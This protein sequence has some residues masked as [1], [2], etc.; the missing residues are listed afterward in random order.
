M[1][2]VLW[3]ASLKL[4]LFI[5]LLLGAVAL[6]LLL[7][8]QVS[9]WVVAVPLSMLVIN[10]LAAIAVNP[11]F[12]VQMPLL[13]FHLAL[14][15]LL[16]LVVAGRLTYL[17]GWTE[18]SEHAEFNGE[19]TGYQAGP[20]HGWG[21][22]NLQFINQGFSIHYLPGPK[23]GKTSNRIGW[24]DEAG[25]Q[26]HA[27]IG[28]GHPL[29]LGGYR[30]YTSFNKGFAPVFTW[31][32][33]NGGE[34]VTGDIHLPAY[35]EH[36]NRQVSEWTPP[37]ET[38]P[39]WMMLDFDEVILDPDHDSFFRVPE[40]HVMI[41]RQAENRHEMRPGSGIDLTGGRLQYNGLR[42]WMGYTVSYD[43]TRP[44]LVAAAILAMSSLG[45]HFVR[46]YSIT[47]WNSDRKSV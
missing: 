23:R 27:E 17:Q 20:L 26:R 4:T 10:L 15:L 19:L 18:V 11:V 35:P 8:T 22:R 31:I 33:N 39:L 34:P 46:K 45:W 13:A 47:P 44:W 41:I 6:L 3:F 24:T 37:G 7:S 32:P 36:A 21:I 5:L 29:V 16:L 25:E 9:A 42:T 2:V 14:L 1:S 28:D 38:S 43:W 30:F 12:R 40:K